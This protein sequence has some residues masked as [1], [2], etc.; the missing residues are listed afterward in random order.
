VKQVLL[1]SAAAALTVAATPPAEPAA[2]PTVA[3]TSTYASKQI[4]RTEIDIGTRL[5]GKRICRTQA[6]WDV[7]RAEARKAA[8]RAQT[9]GSH[10]L[11]TG[12]CGNEGF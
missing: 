10:C 7:V 2:P 8:E 9:Q 3:T 1:L 11:R 6:E 12:M 4:C 5:G